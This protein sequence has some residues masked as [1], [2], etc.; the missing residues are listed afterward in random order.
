MMWKN[1]EEA[2][3]VIERRRHHHSGLEL[4]KKAVAELHD[5]QDQIQT[6]H[7]GGTN[8]KGSTVNYLRSILQRA[9]YRVGTFTSPY[10]ISHHDRILI[11]YI[12]IN[13][14]KHLSNINEKN[15]KR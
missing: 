7:V 11:N 5:P 3:A 6:I 4:F 15:I 1:V 2:I 12:I 13:D 10:L 14:E 9:G 8:G